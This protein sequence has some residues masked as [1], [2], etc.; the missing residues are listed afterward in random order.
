M[1]RKRF[2]NTELSF[3]QER[4]KHTCEYC[5][6]PVRFSPNP[7]HVEHIVPLQAGGTNDLDN[8]AFAC[9]G[10][11]TNKWA[12][13]TWPDPASGQAVRLFHPRTDDW[14]DHFQWN[15]DFTKILAQTAVGRASA[16]LLQLNRE[17]LV[18]IR[19]ALRQFGAHPE[20]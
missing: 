17:G 13:T 14:N 2:S 4:A 3:I 20:N 15:A 12:Y 19:Q 10:C 9:D 18:N 11:N 8:L 5:K 6:F 16:D 1:G 7:F